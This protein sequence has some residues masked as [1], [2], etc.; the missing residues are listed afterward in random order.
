MRESVR[1]EGRPVWEAL[2]THVAGVAKRTRMGHH[3]PLELL[4]D[5]ELHVAHLALE[6]D[7]EAVVSLQE[8]EL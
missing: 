4:Q 7:V 5:L 2:T 1:L 6:R 8:R 3:V